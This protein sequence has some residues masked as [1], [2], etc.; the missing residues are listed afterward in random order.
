MDDYE[1]IKDKIHELLCQLDI[2][3]D[4]EA[5]SKER[6]LGEWEKWYHEGRFDALESF[7]QM[8]SA[9]EQDSPPVCSL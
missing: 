3:K 7:S 2:C 9:I 5:E 1:R 8:L 6:A 4:R